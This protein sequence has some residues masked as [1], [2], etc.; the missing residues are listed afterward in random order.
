MK[1]VLVFC[2][3]RH[4]VVFTQRSLGTH[5]DCAWVDKV[6]SELP[7]PFGSDG[8][9]K[10]GLIAQRIEQHALG[11]LSLRDASHQPLPAFDSVIE[12]TATST[13]YFLIRGHG[14]DQIDAT[15]KLLQDLETTMASVPIGTFD[16]SEYAAAF[17]FDANGEG[18]NTTLGTFRERYG[19][20]FGYFGS[21]EH[22]KWWMT[23]ITVPIGC[24][25]FH[26]GTGDQTGTIED[27]LEPMVR[28][29]WPARYAEAGRFI[30]D[31]A[32]GNDKVSSSKAE[33]LKAT[34]TATGQFDNPGD[35]MSII[36]GRGGLPREQFERSEL[37][38]EL[39]AF[40]VATPWNSED[41]P[42]GT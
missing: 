6:I 26:R 14:Q 1:A 13:I 2:E 4:D 29:A 33:R 3:G 36:I 9:A 27:H 24:F 41:T 15:L 12:N 7:S 8:V 34:I 38:K 11:D 28:R 23:G 37:S 10:R 20:H 17:L 5:G 42:L 22:G 25:V 16:V 30:D 19:T 32:D 18:V 31:N 35:P 40:L 39:A 21:L